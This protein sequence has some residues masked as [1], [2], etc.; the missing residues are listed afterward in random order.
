MP[1]GLADTNT[2]KATGVTS[3]KFEGDVAALNALRGS[4]AG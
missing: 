3:E 1:V 4:I 2:H